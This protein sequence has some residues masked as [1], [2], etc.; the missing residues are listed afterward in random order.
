M[1]D[2]IKSFEKMRNCL[3]ENNHQMWRQAEQRKQI[4]VAFTYHLRTPLTVLKGYCE[5]LKI[6][7]ENSETVNTA[8]T[9]EKHILRLERYV[10][11]MSNLRKFEDTTLY[12]KNINVVEFVNMLEQS[13]RFICTDKN[14]KLTFEDYTDIKNMKIDKDIIYLVVENLVSTAIRYAKTEIAS[15]D[16]IL[17][18]TVSDDG[19]G[20]TVDGLIKATSPYYTQDIDR[21]KHFGLGLYISKVLCEIH[22]GTVVVCNGKNGAIITA[23][24]LYV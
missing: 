20:F 14:I 10:D 22:G 24:F 11:S 4:N 5:I 16:K 21:I 17:M 6:D 13:V 18:I 9:M 23:S 19:I 12:C 15:K 3:Q 7:S 1:G 8:S 2:L